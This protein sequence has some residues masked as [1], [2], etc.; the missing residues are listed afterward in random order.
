MVR[1]VGA[2]V[3]RARVKV[4]EAVAIVLYYVST[5]VSTRVRLDM[6]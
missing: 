1:K 3:R 2:A 5:Y 4:R 6:R